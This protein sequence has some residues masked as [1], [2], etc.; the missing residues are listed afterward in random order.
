MSKNCTPMAKDFSSEATDLRQDR[1]SAAGNSTPDSR[2]VAAVWWLFVWWLF[3]WLCAVCVV[4]V[5]MVRVCGGCLCSGCLR[6]GCVHAGSPEHHHVQGIVG[7]GGDQSCQRDDEDGG[8]EEVWAAVWT[9]AGESLALALGYTHTLSVQ[10]HH[11][12][13][14]NE[15]DLIAP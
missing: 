6:G 7:D 14:N 1:L 3:V 13:E 8:N 9:R 4:G 2:G 10:L 15:Q 5:F 12:E 11:Q